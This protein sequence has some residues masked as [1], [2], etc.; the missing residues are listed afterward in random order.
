MFRQDHP[1]GGGPE[2]VAAEVHHVQGQGPEDQAERRPGD[3]QGG[4]GGQWGAAQVCVWI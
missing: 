4:D 2:E 3:G 1:D